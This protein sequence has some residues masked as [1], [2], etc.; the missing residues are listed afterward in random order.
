MDD[1]Q[2][3]TEML[4]EIGI[5]WEAVVDG[6]MLNADYTI[7]PDSCPNFASIPADEWPVIFVDGDFSVSPSESG[8]GM[9]IVE[10]DLALN[11]TF[12]WEGAILV[13]GYITSNGYQTVE[14]ATLSGLN[15]ALG[16]TVPSTDIGNG[17]KAFKYHS[18]NLK[19]A[20]QAAF[21]GLSPVPGTWAEV[22]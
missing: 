22:L 9:L 15:E 14:G 16:E 12:Q 2:T 17:N 18:C 8:R 6:G 7:P 11:G 3:T 20:A 21:G 1:A 13:G 10:G 19:Q 4:A 5:D